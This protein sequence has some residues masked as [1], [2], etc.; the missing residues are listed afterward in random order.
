MSE[1]EYIKEIPI[2]GYDDLIK[3]I[4]GKDKYEDLREKFI[5]RGLEDS[6]YKLIPSALRDENKLNDFVDE[7][8]KIN[9]VLSHKKAVECGFINE[10]D[11][12]DT[13]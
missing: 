11:F 10:S 7:D 5:F 13:V 12:Y 1:S 8:F 3:I 9:L 2:E 4:Q 6:T